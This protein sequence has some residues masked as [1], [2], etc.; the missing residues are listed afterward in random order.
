MLTHVD[1]GTQWTL[2]KIHS[3]PTNKGNF[4]LGL[5]RKSA[6]TDV[7]LVNGVASEAIGQTR[8]SVVTIGELATAASKHPYY[9]YNT[10]WSRE[11]QD[12]VCD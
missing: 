12:L 9:K 2:A 6:I 3:T 11:V 8:K 1:R 4:S 10:L 5:S 7:S